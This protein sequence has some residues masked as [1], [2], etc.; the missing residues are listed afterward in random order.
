MSLIKILRDGP[1]VSLQ[2]SPT[3]SPITVAL[4][5]SDPFPPRFPD[6]TYFFALSHAPPEFARNTAS[7]KPVV[8]EIHPP[9]DDYS[10]IDEFM[11][12]YFEFENIILNSW[13]EIDIVIENRSGT[14]YVGGIFL[15]SRI[16]DL[17]TLVDKIDR[18]SL[19]LNIALDI[20]SC[21]L[22]MVVLQSFLII[23]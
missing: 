15:L 12:N 23:L 22:H 6:S 21:L 18:T 5:A 2:G 20:H 3:V 11:S 7:K 16:R 4:C 9:F 13:P 10:T 17:L 14:T 8:I 19:R 1:E